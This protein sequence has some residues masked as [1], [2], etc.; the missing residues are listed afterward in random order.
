M[1]IYINFKIA[2]HKFQ[3]LNIFKAL[4]VLSD[5]FS[6]GELTKASKFL[7][8]PIFSNTVLNLCMV[9]K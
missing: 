3:S 6:S 7:K 5:I 8:A 9:Y 4:T 2:L 1:K